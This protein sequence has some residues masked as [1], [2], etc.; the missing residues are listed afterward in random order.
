MEIAIVSLL[1]VTFGLC[2]AIM[3]TLQFH[4][5]KSMFPDTNFWNP[6]KSWKN[7]YKN[8][9]ANQGEKFPFS[10]TLL[11]FT[12]D[13]W[14]L[15]KSIGFNALYFALA[16]TICFFLNLPFRCL[17]LVFASIKILAGAGFYIPYR[18]LLLK[19]EKK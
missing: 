10:T 18:F 6:K 2:N 12:T 4:F 3:D 7:K 15:S 19:K 16:F 17:V 8:G 5:D 9:D 11:V 14:H 1:L 13:A